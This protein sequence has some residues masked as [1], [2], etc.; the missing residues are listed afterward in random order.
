MF[1]LTVVGDTRIPQIIPHLVSPPSKVGGILS[2]KAYLLA[3]SIIVFLLAA[4]ANAA[5]TS[6]DAEISVND[7]GST[8]WVVNLTYNTT[9]TKSD[10]FVFSTATNI[11]VFTDKEPV[12]CDV[13]TDI[14]TSIVCDNIAAKEVIYKFHVKGLAS[15]IQNLKIF[16][17]A[18]SVTQ[19]VDRMHVAVKL[20]LGAALVESLKLGGTGLKPFEPDFGREG[21]DGRR[22]FVSWAFDK[23]VLGQ[24]INVYAIYEVISGIDPFLLFAIILVLVVV[25]FLLTIMFV[26]RKQRI[27]D[28]LP[29]L[30]E[31]ERKVMEI[32]LRDKEADQRAIVKETDFSKAKVSRVINDL[33]E[34]GLVEK[35][36]RG[37]KNIIKLKKEVK[38]AEPKSA[39]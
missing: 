7:D 9:V 2:M 32:L 27:R 6:W 14:G 36:A 24:T 39:K 4:T 16:R 19:S 35:T 21:S 38:R 34:R 20:P 31:G 30:T 29:V 37:R 10:Y 26:F 22:I 18:F 3:A 23:P 8:D 11:E 28:I 33:I 25:A 1:Y 12:S 13:S 17:Y 15:N 5:L